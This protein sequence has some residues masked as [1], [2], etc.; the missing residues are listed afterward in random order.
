MSDLAPGRVMWRT[1]RERASDPVAVYSSPS[2]PPLSPA[3]K[4]RRQAG[5]RIKL[6]RV[7]KYWE[8]LL[9]PFPLPADLPTLNPSFL[10]STSDTRFL[11]FSFLFLA[12]VLRPLL[13]HG[14]CIYTWGPFFSSRETSSKDRYA[15]IITNT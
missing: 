1:C 7:H 2:L 9:L 14:S 13:L 15:S 6:A 8:L 3:R 10:L 4:I 5:A 11:R 12:P